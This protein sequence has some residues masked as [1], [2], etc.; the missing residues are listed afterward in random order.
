MAYKH[1]H[2]DVPQPSAVRPELPDYVDALVAR[3]TARER[4]QRSADARVLLQQVR[5]VQQALGAGVA[6]DPDLV[7][8]LEPRD[9]PDEGA[10]PS[11]TAHPGAAA[12]LAAAAGPDDEATQAVPLAGPDDPTVTVDRAG[13]PAE[14]TMQW[15]SE[16][17]GPAPARRPPPRPPGCTRP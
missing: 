6:S 9:R 14:P 10:A 15:S 12:S 17:W 3:A 1:V 2:E 13:P 16:Q 8:D 11:S 7:A 4:D 5:R